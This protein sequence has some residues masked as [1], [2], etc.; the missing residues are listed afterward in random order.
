MG[1]THLSTSMS[2]H[3][4]P[5]G[6]DLHCSY[7]KWPSDN[8]RVYFDTSIGAEVKCFPSS[9][10]VY[11]HRCSPME[12]DFLNLPLCDTVPPS[13]DPAV[14]DAFCARLQLLGAKWFP[15]MADKHEYDGVKTQEKWGSIGYIRG[16]FG[17]FSLL[18]LFLRTY[19]TTLFC[20]YFLL[21]YFSHSNVTVI[22]PA[23]FAQCGYYMRMA[24]SS[25]IFPTLFEPPSTYARAFNAQNLKEEALPAY[26]TVQKDQKLTRT[27]H[28]QPQ[29][30]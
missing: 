3:Y 8:L 10:G 14:E 11:V 20:T 26:E 28:R 27:E 21:L 22:S 30:E 17:P 23:L 25:F 9:G 18:S 16:A 6:V 4:H 12:L 2:D 19:N 1:S 24:S 29:L 13:S 15:S 5:P 7:T